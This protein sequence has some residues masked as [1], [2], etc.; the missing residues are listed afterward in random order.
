MVNSKKKGNRVEREMA[1]ILSDRFGQ[2][3]KRVPASGAIGTQLHGID[4]REDAQE[5]L[6]GDLICPKKFTFSV[7][8]KSRESFNFWDLIADD[9][10][11]EI[12]DWIMQAEGDAIAS[13]KE[14]LIIFKA[15]NRKP[16]VLFPKRLKG[17]KLIY[18]DY[19]ILRMD[20]FLKIEDEFF[21]EK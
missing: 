4:I 5:I 2:T 21:W 9:T 1:K 6:S 8:V 16:F 12:D 3:F 10:I 20:Y 18:G 19:T 15:N 13:K 11:N 14:P 7:E 17:G